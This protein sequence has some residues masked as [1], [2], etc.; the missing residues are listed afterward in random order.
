MRIMTFI[1][2]GIAAVGLAV[3]YLMGETA[4][5]FTLPL[6]LLS[7]SA[8]VL[9]LLISLAARLFKR[10]KKYQCLNCGMYLRGGD[11]VR[12]GNV[13]PNCGGNAFR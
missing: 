11:P 4:P 5:A 13:C 1:S 10:R 12:L 2:I 8:A 9:F 6:I 7:G 3:Y